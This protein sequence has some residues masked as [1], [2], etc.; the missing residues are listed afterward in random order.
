MRI[1]IETSGDLDRI[2]VASECD[3]RFAAEP[4]GRLALVWL[5]VLQRR[6]LAAPGVTPALPAWQ[7]ALSKLLHLAL[8]A[9]FIVMPLLGLATAWLDG[10]MLYLPF[11]QIMVPPL[12][13]ENE[14]LAHTVEDL[15][16]L[17][18]N[19]FY[20]VIGLHIVAALYHHFVRRDDTLKRIL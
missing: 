11:T 1:L 16:K 10:K 19:I 8:Y 18:G 12:L 14:A 2:T 6:G 7:S 9:F 5:R 4:G 3:A 17:V 20:W 15:H 13:A